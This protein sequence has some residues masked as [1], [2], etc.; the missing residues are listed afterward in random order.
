MNFFHH[1]VSLKKT[2]Q[3]MFAKCCGWKVQLKLT[4]NGSRPS[5]ITKPSTRC[6]R[7]C[8]VSI[9]SGLP[10]T[11]AGDEGGWLGPR[12]AAGMMGGGRGGD[13]GGGLLLLL[14]LVVV[15]WDGSSTTGDLITEWLDMMEDEPITAESKGG[16]KDNRAENK[17]TASPQ[18]EPIWLKRTISSN[19]D[20]T[21]VTTCFF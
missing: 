8:V 15:S 21:A 3:D 18:A 11:L 17:I 16:R 1:G 13:G 9:L 19:V 5:R 7:T 4:G 20:S 12:T 14:L 2:K 6:V 10:G